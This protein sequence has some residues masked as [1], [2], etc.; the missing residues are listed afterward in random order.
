[1]YMLNQTLNLKFPGHL[2]LP[3]KLNVTAVLSKIEF[4]DYFMVK[5]IPNLH[6]KK[7]TITFIYLV[8]KIA[9]C[10]AVVHKPYSNCR[11]YNR[12]SIINR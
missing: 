7:T 12:Q 11:V 2:C 1:M 8:E 5:N 3:C 10:G 6:A 4:S 9:V